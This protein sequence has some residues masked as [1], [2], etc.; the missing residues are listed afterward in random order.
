M[1]ECPDKCTITDDKSLVHE[2][3]AIVVMGLDDR[4]DDPDR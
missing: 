3:D 4:T 2:T 1:D